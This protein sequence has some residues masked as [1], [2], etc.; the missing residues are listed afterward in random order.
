MAVVAPEI[1]APHFVFSSN[2]TSLG[3]LFCSSTSVLVSVELEPV[4]NMVLDLM[5]RK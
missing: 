3:V 1:A 2:V 5:C 4:F